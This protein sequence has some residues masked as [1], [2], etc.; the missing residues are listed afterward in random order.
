M[1]LAIDFFVERRLGNPQIKIIIDDYIT[2][3]NGDA[4][5]NFQFDIDLPNGIKFFLE[6]LILHQYY[7]NFLHA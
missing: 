5:D 2:L 4:Q 1:N 3:Y 6:P 7:S